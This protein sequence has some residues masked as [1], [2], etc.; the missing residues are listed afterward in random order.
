MKIYSVVSTHLLKKYLYCGVCMALMGI[1]VLISAGIFIPVEQLKNYGFILFFF[2]FGLIACGLVPY[3]RLHMLQLKPYEMCFINDKSFH[4][5]RSNQKLLTLQIADI[6]K[7]AYK[8]QFFYYGI[9]IFLKNRS[10]L[11]LPYFN[12]KSFITLQNFLYDKEN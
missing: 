9:E 6:E 3:K 7:I 2:S 10:T 12:H 4:F 8:D 1:I 11:S 5:G